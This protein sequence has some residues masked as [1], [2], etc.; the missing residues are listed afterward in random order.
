VPDTGC[1]GSAVQLADLDGDGRVEIVAAYADEPD[2]GAGRCASQG[3][4][5]A[6]RIELP[7]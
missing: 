5:N 2:T 6:F 1:S 3:M 4:V 7:R